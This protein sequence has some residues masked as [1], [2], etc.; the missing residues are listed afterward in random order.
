MVVDYIYFLFAC[1]AGA[2]QAW[3]FDYGSD[4]KLTIILG[5]F[6]SLPFALASYAHA[7]MLSRSGAVT[8]RP[9]WRRLFILW[10][11]MPLSLAIGALTIH[12]E[13]GTMHV[14]GYDNDH[15]PFYSLRI[16]IGEAVACSAWA[17]CLLLWL[18]HNRKPRSR[19]RFFIVFAMLF[20]G[21]LLA[22]GFSALVGRSSSKYFLVTSIVET[23]LSAL[24][25]IFTKARER[26]A[27]V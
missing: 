6:M 2:W 1:I 15:L 5:A 12:V 11:G 7:S 23:A 25:V 20:A 27:H 24:I 16:L 10:V 4:N 22:Y 18:R 21:V 3:C 8:E 17:M 13:T 9:D 26:M 19:Y 14:V